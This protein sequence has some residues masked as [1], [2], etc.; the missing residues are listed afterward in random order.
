VY[1]VLREPA[2][3][4]R[5]SDELIQ[6]A[7]YNRYAYYEAIGRAQIEWVRALQAR[8]RAQIET[9]A[10]TIGALEATGT[11]LEASTRNSLNFIL[12]SA[13]KELHRQPSGRR[14]VVAE[15]ERGTSKSKG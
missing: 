4:N 5:I 14:P 11:E 3:V 9:F 7:R 12:S 15:H 1:V 2:A 8:S 10:Q 6:I 13:T